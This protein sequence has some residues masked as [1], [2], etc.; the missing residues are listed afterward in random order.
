MDIFLARQAIYDKNHKVVAYEIFFRNSNLN[1]FDYK[2]NEDIA[3]M[4]VLSNCITIG[5]E[6][7]T[8]KKRAFI[9]C[10]EGILKQ[11]IPSILNKEIVVVEILESVS[12]REDIL[13]YLQ[14]LK[15]SGYILSLDSVK[16]DLKIKQYGNLIDIYKID[17]LNT[18]KEEREILLR[19]IKE[20]NKHA[21]LCA[22]KIENK[23][24]Y[25]EA[26]LNGYE[27][28]QGYYLSK[29]VM[30][31]GKDIPVTRI[32]RFD[33]ISESCSDNVDINRL[34]NIIKSDVA[35]S[36]KLIKFLNYS[37]FLKGKKINSIREA[38]ILI[39]K[40]NL[41]K[42]FSIIAANEMN[43][44]EDEEILNN[45]LSTSR[46]CELIASKLTSKKEELAFLLGIL[47]KI[48]IFI[49]KDMKEVSRELP[50]NYEVKESLLGEKNELTYI[51]KLA[52]SYENMDLIKI[53]D[54]CN[55]LRINKE[56]L[57]ELYIESIR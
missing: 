1:V 51:L 56:E 14:D 28:F 20:I 21:I 44:N 57:M 23:D 35:L 54:Y 53:K 39:G 29:P 32:N 46:F 13:N 15:N 37:E 31:L 48:D 16:C 40:D 8:N 25:D 5:I 36:Y 50:I 34:E 33:V 47:S 17:F 22:E 52:Q 42:L 27:Y 11:H 26:I 43:G 45:I 3:T 12:Q 55:K 38:I 6:N 9:N 7:I 49:D 24:Q 19:E 18:C 41:K 10:S 30:I 4:K 2:I